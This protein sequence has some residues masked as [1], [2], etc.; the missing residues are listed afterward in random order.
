MLAKELETIFLDHPDGAEA[1]AFL[2]NFG[3]YCHCID[4]LV[5][6]DIKQTPEVFGAVLIMATNLYS[7]S[8]YNK[9]QHILYQVVRGIHHTY[10]DSVRM[11][12]SSEMKNK[13]QADA[14]KSVGIQMTLTIIEIL[15]S[16]ANRRRLSQL[17]YDHAY[18]KQHD[19]DG[20]PLP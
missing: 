17:V 8:F 12:R 1:K 13:E 14:L 6:G 5:D 15:S 11:E 3:M 4:D 10:F 2:A 9:Y 18:E 20:N 16:Y 19:G 7:C